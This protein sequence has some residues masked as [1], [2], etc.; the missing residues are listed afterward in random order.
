MLLWFQV[1]VYF[2]A[3]LNIGN[4]P[5]S[6]AYGGSIYAPQT[7]NSHLFRM[8]WK[9]SFSF[10]KSPTSINLHL[11]CILGRGVRSKRNQKS[12]DFSLNC[13]PKPHLQFISC[14]NRCSNRR[15]KWAS[16]V[17]L[18]HALEA[19][20]A[21]RVF[22]E[23]SPDGF[24]GCLAKHPRKPKK[25]VGISLRKMEIPNLGNYGGGIIFFSGS[26]P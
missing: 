17:P 3:F 7:N 18:L 10:G 4:D 23:F 8:T 16:D 14:S 25:C 2:F 26:N 1:F 20:V 24:V 9:T 5:I 12:P 13:S 11:P 21:R 6:T 22:V 15:F 19:M